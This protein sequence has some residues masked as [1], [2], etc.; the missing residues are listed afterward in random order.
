MM[1]YVITIRVIIL[2]YLKKWKGDRG[3]K[4][5]MNDRWYFQNVYKFLA[6]WKMLKSKK[7]VKSE[8]IT[9]CYNTLKLLKYCNVKFKLQVS[10]IW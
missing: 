7:I 5:I 3:S 8:Q 10:T 9:S 4:K 6:M 2:L 1:W